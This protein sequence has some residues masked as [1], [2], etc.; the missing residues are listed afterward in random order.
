MCNFSP[1]EKKSGVFIC[2]FL[3]F[4]AVNLVN[5]MIVDGLGHVSL[6][7]G[8]ALPANAMNNQ[9]AANIHQGS[10]PATGR[11]DASSNASN[12]KPTTPMSA[13]NSLQFNQLIGG[14]VAPSLVMAHQQPHQQ[15]V[16]SSQQGLSLVQ[17][18]QAAPAA[19]ANGAVNLANNLM[20][21]DYAQSG[22]MGGGQN[23]AAFRH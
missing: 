6:D 13:A 1:R 10:I 3:S 11:K 9:Q 21:G 22:M 12:S 15:Q 16:V 4:Q 20:I 14:A 5:G 23:A 18:P 19:A 7:S 17:Q 8:P 2:A